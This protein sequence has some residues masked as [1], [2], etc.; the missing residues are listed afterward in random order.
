MRET[1]NITSALEVA[2]GVKHI[3]VRNVTGTVSGA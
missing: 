3:N 2:V 1:E